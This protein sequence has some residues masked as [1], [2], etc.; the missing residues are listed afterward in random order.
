M[1]RKLVFLTEEGQTKLV[2][3]LEMLRSLKR[4]EVAERI[5]RAKDMEST[6][7]NA[8]YDDAKNEQAFIEGRIL[9]VETMLKNASIVHVE[10]SHNKVSIGS[11][12][13]LIA[14]E[15]EEETYTIVG[16]IEAK[17]ADGRISNESPVG[18]A[19]L[20]RRVGQVVQ[21]TTPAGV[22][23]LKIVHVE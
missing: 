20:G 9:T 11:R 23:R 5:Q 22:R 17:A 19:L 12:V 13:T 6:V 1:D 4:P 8:E 2:A 14:P 16:S 21:V 3:E 18:Q 15:G 7:N 10:G